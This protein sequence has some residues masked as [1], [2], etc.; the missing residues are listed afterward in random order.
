M[1]PG[2]QFPIQNLMQHYNREVNYSKGN[3]FETW[4]LARERALVGRSLDPLITKR[5]YKS[6]L[7]IACHAGEYSFLLASKGLLTLGVD[8]SDKA[9]TVAEARRRKAGISTITFKKLDATRLGLG[10]TF[11][12]IIL[13][14][15]LHHFPDDLAEKTLRLAIQHLSPGGT[16]FFDLKNRHNPVL[17]YVY[18]RASS[19][20]LLLRDRTYGFFR[21]VV[22]QAG[23]HVVARRALMTPAWFLE[24]FVILQVEK[25]PDIPRPVSESH[26]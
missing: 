16:L 17:R 23:A 19:D 3:R 18:R 25:K 21:E 24:P 22:N 14:E 7:D 10:R 20:R 4:H 6:A 5:H 26:E 2:D 8:T 9:L 15:L 11:D 12:V 1:K 13:M